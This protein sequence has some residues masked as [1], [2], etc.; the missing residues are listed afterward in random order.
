MGDFGFSGSIGNSGAVTS[1]A[2]PA[3]ICDD[4]AASGKFSG[5][6]ANS[7]AI[8]ADAARPS[9]RRYRQCQFVFRHHHQQRR[10]D[11]AWNWCRNCRNRRYE[12]L[13]SYR[14]QR[15][16]LAQLAQALTSRC[17]EAGKFSGSVLN[18]G[19]ISAHTVVSKSRI[20]AL[21]D[22]SGTIANGGVDHA[23]PWALFVGSVA[24]N[25][26]F[27][28]KYCQYRQGSI[29]ANMT[30]MS[31]KMPAVRSFSGTISN[32]GKIVSTTD[33]GI[34][35]LDRRR[36]RYSKA[37]SL[38]PASIRANS[39]GIP[40][41]ISRHTFSGRHHQQRRDQRSSARHGRRQRCQ[42][43]FGTVVD[44]ATGTIAGADRH[45]H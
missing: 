34:E 38:T 20:P 9:H 14:Q 11:G 45:P 30:G 12:F 19:A 33:K 24:T 44:A 37:A 4:L 28:R 29:V 18:T 1:A 36:R 8:S 31:V 21:P 26:T 35:V 15:R 3:S 27:H 39:T 10:R 16:H 25:G 5:T 23:R 43:F 40:S 32:N 2:S 17:P 6:I 41:T 42:S 7:G 13:R 22:F